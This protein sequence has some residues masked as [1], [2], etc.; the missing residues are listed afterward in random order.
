M[1]YARVALAKNR[2]WADC[3]DASHSAELVRGYFPANP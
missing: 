1:T 3:A 2:R